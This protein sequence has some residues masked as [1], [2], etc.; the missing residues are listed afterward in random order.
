MLTLRPIY[1]QPITPACPL[2][3]SESR[4]PLCDLYSHFEWMAQHGYP[5][6]S[7]DKSKRK[8]LIEAFGKGRTA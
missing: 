7:I 1:E 2:C 5:G 6:C 4:H 3:K 8:M